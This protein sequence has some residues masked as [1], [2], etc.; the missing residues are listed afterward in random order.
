VGN[1][2]GNFIVSGITTVVVIFHDKTQN[3]II[4][5]T[6]I[7]VAVFV[8]MEIAK[9]VFDFGILQ[10]FLRLPFQTAILCY[11]HYFVGWHVLTAFVLVF[12]TVWQSYYMHIFTERQVI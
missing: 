5:Q 8:F 9:P 2:V 12:G 7:A 10:F 1:M 4:W 6:L 3:G 11:R